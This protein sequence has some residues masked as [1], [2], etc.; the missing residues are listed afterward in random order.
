MEVLVET[1]APTPA[2]A[3]KA[4]TGMTQA[5]IDMNFIGD[6]SDSQVNE[7]I[8][9]MTPAPVQRII[10]EF[11]CLG[12]LDGGSEWLQQMVLERYIQADCE[13][14]FIRITFGLLW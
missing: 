14:V 11:E 12:K 8:S 2:P 10:Q 6:L 7:L 3:G 4:P 5:T 1:P 13:C 9:R